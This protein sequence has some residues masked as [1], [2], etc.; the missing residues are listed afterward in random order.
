MTSGHLVTDSDLPLLGDI[1]L[2]DLHNAVRK[3]VTD[4]YLVHLSLALGLSHLVGQAVVVDEFLDEQVGVL[5]GGPVAG[6]DVLEVNGLQFLNADLLALGDDLDIVEVVDARALL[7]LCQDGQSLEEISVQ[8]RGLLVKLLLNK[9]KA[10]F[11]ISFGGSSVALFGGFG[12]ERC[13]DDCSAERRISL[14]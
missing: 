1:D 12:V 8:L 6:V 13:L 3:L 4:L 9:V 7:A 5:I 2:G 10:C 11:L 14:E